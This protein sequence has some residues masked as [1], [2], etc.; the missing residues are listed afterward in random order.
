MIT[1]VQR[2]KY[3]LIKN[4]LGMLFLCSSLGFATGNNKGPAEKTGQ[5][6]DRA[7]EKATQYVEDSAITAAVKAEIM[8][9]PTLKSNQ[10]SV[11]TQNGVVELVGVLDSQDSIN[12]AMEIARSTKNVISV[13]NNLYLRR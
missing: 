13:K 6:I 1:K 10:I 11:E 2:N 9:E 12:R 7:N 5:K 8:K 4:I 3:S